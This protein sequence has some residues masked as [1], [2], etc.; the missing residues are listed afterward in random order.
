M[1]AASRMFFMY[2]LCSPCSLC[3]RSCPYLCTPRKTRPPYPHNRTHFPGLSGRND[4]T[5]GFLFHS[6][7][8]VHCLFPSHLKGGATFLSP[9]KA[10]NSYLRL[11]SENSNQQGKYSHYLR[12]PRLWVA[13]LSYVGGDRGQGFFGGETWNRDTI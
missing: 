12:I 3:L 8:T 13:I 9:A 11:G 10:I 2:G 5:H 4:H 6:A 1:S 7:S